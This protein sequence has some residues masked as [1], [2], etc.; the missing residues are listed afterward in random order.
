MYTMY[1]IDTMYFK[2][3]NNISTVE[4]NKQINRYPII[5]ALS[6]EKNQEALK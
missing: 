3:Y 4:R 6:K 2:T 1:S 5:L